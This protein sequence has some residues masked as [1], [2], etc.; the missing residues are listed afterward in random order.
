MVDP[1]FGVQ[2]PYDQEGNQE[3]F[4]FRF[5]TLDESRAKSET[6]TNRQS[7][8]GQEDEDAVL[9]PVSG[10]R[11]H[12]LS[13]EA[14]YRVIDNEYDTLSR[15]ESVRRYIR[16]LEALVL[17]QQGA[18]WRVDDTVRGQSKSPVSDD[19]GFLFEEVGWEHDA[20]EPGRIKY[21]ADLVTANGVQDTTNPDNYISRR[22]EGYN[23][24]DK[25]VVGDDVT[26]EFAQVDS[27]RVSRSVDVQRNDLM[28]QLD[29]G[30]GGGDGGDGDD[31]GG[32]PVIGVVQ[33]GVETEVNIQGTV[34][35]PDDF[36]STVREFDKEIHGSTAF[37]YDALSGA[38]WEG[39]IS[40][41]SSTLE[42]GKPKNRFG[43]SIDIEIGRN[44]ADG[45]S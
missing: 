19:R 13:G 26:I 2:G 8:F 7:I 27:R 25:V 17:S 35:A 33:S 34:I 42:A 20:S 43:A 16:E 4:S 23:G 9:S 14:G 22:S 39:A 24:V 36:E 15:K 1:A 38:V 6:D 21:D 44:L 45:G 37:F 12:S 41:S 28:H 18:G 30:G 32:S 31:S 5:L 10:S 11:S 29:S 3:F 40:S